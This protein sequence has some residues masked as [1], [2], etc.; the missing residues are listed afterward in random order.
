MKRFISQMKGRE[1]TF[2]KFLD[3]I[4][5]FHPQ[6]GKILDVGTAGGSFLHAA[7][8][9]GW[10][11]YGCEPNRWLCDWSKKHYGI[12]IKSGT[13]FEQKYQQ[14]FLTWLPFGMSLNI[15]LIRKKF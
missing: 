13:I 7:K 11:V 5:K 2:G 4:G 15:P 10:D 12:D 3:K 8:Q 14:N 6:P 9:R 1:N